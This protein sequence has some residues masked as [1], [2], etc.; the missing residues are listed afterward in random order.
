[1]NC[2]TATPYKLLAPD[3][4][5]VPFIFNSPHSGRYY[6]KKFLAA[7]KLEPHAL[8]RSEDFLVDE[9]FASA[10]DCGAPLLSALFPRAWLDVN[11]EP[12]ELDPTM[13]AEKLP[14]FVNTES[15]R[16]AGGLGTIARIV[17]ETDEIYRGKL[18]A[19]EAFD[20]IERVYKPY[21]RALRD[22][23]AQALARFGYAV[24]VDCHSMP[25][26]ET[27]SISGYH[28]TRR[29][30]FVLGDRYG[31]SCASPI[32]EAAH[33]CLRDLG[34]RV[35][36]N[37]PYAGGFITEHY[38][39]PQRGLHAIQIEINRALYMNEATMEKSMG[40]EKLRTDLALFVSRLIDL[41]AGGLIGSLP[42]A[43]E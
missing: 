13:F 15:S 37:K 20:R 24:L 3:E 6:S 11:R 42:L 2:Y 34:Y 21:H 18:T 5:S 40:Y 12:Y 14:A 39:R 43:A 29:A 4:C 17:S 38:G 32:M 10:A 27:L 35:S 19:A 7:S 25:S 41:P 33:E 16:V 9:L 31:T 26:T 8:R 22:L 1:M 30:D 36:L 28:N 23:I